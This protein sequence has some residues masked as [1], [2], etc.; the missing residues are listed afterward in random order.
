[1][2]KTRKFGQ[3]APPPLDEDLFA[4]YLH[5][6][7]MVIFNGNRAASARALG[8]TPLTF[9]A[10]VNKPPKNPWWNMILERTIRDMVR[11]LSISPYKKH[12][13]RAKKVL[14]RMQD[15]PSAKVLYDAILSD[16]VA[17]EGAT[18][19]I[20]MLLNET[21]G[22][23]LTLHQLRQR[24]NRSARTIRIAAQRLCLTVETTGFGEDKATYISI[25][26]SEEP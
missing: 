9:Q 2:P 1:M 7:H 4:E 22:Q 6:L 14:T 25:P 19:D 18:K 5:L 13:K 17:D 24:S 16:E 15:L 20:L 23:T 11:Q 10:Y 26:R 21:P 12:N 8:I 3:Y